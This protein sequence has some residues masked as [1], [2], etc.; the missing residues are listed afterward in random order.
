MYSAGL[1]GNDTVLYLDNLRTIPFTSTGGYF[2]VSGGIGIYYHFTYSTKV[3]NFTICSGTTTTTTAAPTTTTTTEAPTTTTTTE[4]PTTTTTTAAP[5]TTTT[6][7]A[8]TTTTTSTTTTT[9]TG[10]PNLFLQYENG[11]SGTDTWQVEY[12]TGVGYD[13]AVVITT[14]DSFGAGPTIS[15]T[16]SSGPIGITSTLTPFNVRVRKTS[17]SGNMSDATSFGLYID[18]GEGFVSVAGF[19]LT[20]GDNPIGPTA[21]RDITTNFGSPTA[22]P[23]NRIQ[24]QILEG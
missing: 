18:N 9:T 14:A 7:E 16:W 13:N 20:I 23:G 10:A 21:W 15:S 5:T 8:P 6:T 24:V 17:N 3:D 12:S 22:S 11:V 19:S 4:A 1:I 2:W